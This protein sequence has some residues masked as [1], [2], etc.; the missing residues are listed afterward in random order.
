MKP[1]HCMTQG[2]SLFNSRFVF[3]E[4]P[5]EQPKVVAKGGTEDVKD[6]AREMLETSELDFRTPQQ[7][8]A[9]FPK[10]FADTF[11]ELGDS[12][13]KENMEK[14]AKAMPVDTSRTHKPAE[15]PTAVAKKSS[16]KGTVVS[17]K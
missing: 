4:T 9:D 5:H 1:L 3:A 8:K 15:A 13:V 14:M 17:K 12:I 2:F 11:A 10:D 16:A 7:R 6:K